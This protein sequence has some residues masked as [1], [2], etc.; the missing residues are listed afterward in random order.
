MDRVLGIVGG[1]G[2]L[3]TVK[4][5]EKIVMLTDAKCD[6]DHLHII[7]DNNTSIPDRTSYLIG[8]GE[9]PR[10]YLI[11][12]AK[13]LC[14]MGADYLIMPCNTAHYFYS[15]IVKEINIPFLHMIEETARKIKSDNPESVK[16][17]LL[18]TE[19]TCK[20]GVYDDIFREYGMQVIKPSIEKQKYVSDII[21]GIK[22]NR[23]IDIGSFL[24]AAEELK[25]AGCET[26]VLGCTELSVLHAQHK[27]QGNFVDPMEI[28][29]RS[30]IC[31]G[32]KKCKV[33]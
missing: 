15:D 24:S 13:L 14:T 17:G 7:V 6:Q 16:V 25:A 8:A 30:A 33:Y 5:L 27:L 21:Y 3:A 12:S 10:E 31:F 1:M 2:P 22:E 9:D 23:G 29:A 20:T 32:G 28:I 18:A 26:F 4:L 11:H 19:G